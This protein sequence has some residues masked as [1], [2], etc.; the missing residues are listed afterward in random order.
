MIKNKEKASLHGLMD[1]AIMEAGRMENK[2][3]MDYIR[4]KVEI[5]NKVNGKMEK[6]S[7]GLLKNEDKSS[8]LN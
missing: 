6:K 4:I 1:E 2:M 5:L 3:E 8:W 7:N